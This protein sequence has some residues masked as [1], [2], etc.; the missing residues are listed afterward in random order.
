[1]KKYLYVS[2][3]ILALLLVGMVFA[4]RASPALTAQDSSVLARITWSQSELDVILP[5]NV[6]RI[7]DITLTSSQDLQNVSI[8]AIP[9]L[10]G[11]LSTQPNTLEAVP[12]NQHQTIRLI[13][14][15]P[16]TTA[17]GIYDGTIHVRS[18]NRTI[19]DTLKITLTISDQTLPPDP[20]E[21]GKAT[22][23][24]IDADL[25]GVRDDIQRYIVLT[26]PDSEKT[27]EGLFQ[28]IRSVDAFMMKATT[29]ENAYT[30]ANQ[31]SEA[32]W[33]LQYILG[34]DEAVTARRILLAEFLNTQARFTAYSNADSKLS[35]QVFTAPGR[36]DKSQFCK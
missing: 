31:T 26:Y 15:I 19:P 9:E 1:M 29:P 35:G 18:G 8:K 24:G 10:E 21:A 33:C 12:G 32:R 23:E 3:G 7:K 20:G 34:F 17:L 22:I 16:S 11:F 28:Y 4:L 5:R 14:V 36:V 13:F 2:S 6:T 27:R 25:D 30:L